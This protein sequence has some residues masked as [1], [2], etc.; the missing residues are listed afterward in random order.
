MTAIIRS[1]MLCTIQSVIQSYFYT[2]SS[3]AYSIKIISCAEQQSEVLCVIT[4]TGT[5]ANKL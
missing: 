2:Y 5:A 4:G 3:N 1:E